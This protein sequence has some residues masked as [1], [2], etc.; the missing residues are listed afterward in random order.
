MGWRSWNCYQ[1]EVTQA[2]IERVVDA[3]ARKRAAH[4]TSLRELGYVNIGLDDNWQECREGSYHDEDGNER[5]KWVGGR[6]IQ[7]EGPSKTKKRLIIFRS[8]KVEAQHSD[9]VRTQLQN[10]ARRRDVKRWVFKMNPKL[11][12]KELRLIKELHN[13]IAAVE[14]GT[15]DPSN[16]DQPNWNE[17]IPNN[18]PELRQQLWIQKFNMLHIHFFGEFPSLRGPNVCFGVVTNYLRSGGPGR[19]AALAAFNEAFPPEMAVWWERQRQTSSTSEGYRMLTANPNNPFFSER[20]HLLQDNNMWDES[21]VVDWNIDEI[22]PSNVRTR[23]VCL[24]ST[25][26]NIRQ[27]HHNDYL[28]V[29][30][31]TLIA[32]HVM[33]CKK[34]TYAQDVKTNDGGPPYR[35]S[36]FSGIL[37]TKVGGESKWVIRT[38]NGLEYYMRTFIDGVDPAEGIYCDPRLLPAPHKFLLFEDYLTEDGQAPGASGLTPDQWNDR[39]RENYQSYVNNRTIPAISYTGN[40][41]RVPDFLLNGQ[42]HRRHVKNNGHVKWQIA[43]DGGG[44]IRLGMKI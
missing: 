23:L 1:D 39:H 24:R 37:K 6:I 30:G 43:D 18:A 16:I 7:P 11:V 13:F 44:F 17:W 10:V 32:I 41:W 36:Q 12:K 3:V 25:T 29:F 19:E 40:D 27:P 21:V 38:E 31:S 22:L 34:D 20:I 9:Q 15:F 14:N 5:V 42:E 4:G 26:E 35:L 2:K 33:S 8:M 28:A